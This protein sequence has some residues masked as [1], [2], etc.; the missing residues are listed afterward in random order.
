MVALRVIQKLVQF[1]D[2]NARKAPA[3]L[4]RDVASRLD[5]ETIVRPASCPAR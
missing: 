1:H 5:H 3:Q 2:A 4:R